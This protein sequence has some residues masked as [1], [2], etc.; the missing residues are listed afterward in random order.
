MDYLIVLIILLYVA[1]FIWFYIKIRKNIA[2]RIEPRWTPER[3]YSKAEI[4]AKSM[5]YWEKRLHVASNATEKAHC[6][7]NIRAAQRVL[8]ESTGDYVP[9]QAKRDLSE[10][11]PTLVEQKPV[12]PYLLKKELE[13]EPRKLP[14]NV[15]ILAHAKGLKKGDD[16]FE[17]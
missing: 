9:S 15:I 3:E 12:Q 4:A 8:M 1:L 11:L 2:L 17:D 7:D 5:G 13:K 6:F 16:F 10:P 14:K